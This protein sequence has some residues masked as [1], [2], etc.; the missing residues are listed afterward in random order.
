MEGK[1][2]QNNLKGPV[3]QHLHGHLYF[4]CVLTIKLSVDLIF[5]YFMEC[6][7][8]FIPHTVRF[9]CQMKVTTYFSWPSALIG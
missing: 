2:T 6:F 1:L 7:F 3:F 5:C 8:L 9:G 4:L